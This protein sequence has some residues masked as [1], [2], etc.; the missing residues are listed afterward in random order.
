MTLK[1][2]SLT[3]HAQNSAGLMVDPCTVHAKGYE[4]L[5]IGWTASGLGLGYYNDGTGSWSSLDHLSY[6]L[7]SLQGL[8]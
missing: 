5:Q 8:I 6:S 1:P 4:A 7:N 2:R 3:V